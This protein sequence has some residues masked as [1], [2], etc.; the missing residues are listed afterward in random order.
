MEIT[1]CTLTEAATVKC[2]FLF[3]NDTATTEIYTLSLHDALPI[4][5]S[6]KPFL[7]FWRRRGCPIHRAF[8]DEWVLVA[9]QKVKYVRYS[10]FHDR[11]SADRLGLRAGRHGTESDLGGHGRDQ[12]DPWRHDRARHVR[13]VHVVPRQRDERLHTAGSRDRWWFDSRH[14]RVLAVGELGDRPVPV[15]E[16]ALQDRKS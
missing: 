9:A 1:K 6:T 7:R 12:P 11:W 3:F 5:R 4:T 13:H 10:R 8:C 14:H 16:P 15:D 2:F